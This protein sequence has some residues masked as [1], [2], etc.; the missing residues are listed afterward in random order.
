MESKGNFIDGSWLEVS[1]ADASGTIERENPS[2]IDEIVF[3]SNWSTAPVDLAVDAA[4]RALPAWDRLGFDGRLAIMQKFAGVLDANQE[5]LAARIAEEVG[6][7]LWEARGEARALAAKIKLM[8]T[9]GMRYTRTYS[10]DGVQGSTIHRPLG[11]LAV[12]GPFN[13]PMHLPNGHIVPGL[14]NGNT[15]VVKP[16]EMAGGCMQ[17]YFECAEEAGFPPGVL[18]LVQGPGPVGA[19]LST[20]EGVHGVLFTGSYETGLKIKQATLTQH[21]KLLALEMGGKNTSIVLEDANIEQTAHELIQAA[22]LT[23]GQRCTATSRVV[24]RREILDQL[25]ERV[26]DLARRITTGDAVSETA[27]MGPLIDA[28]AMEKFLAAQRDDEDG[29][30]ERILA[31]GEARPDLDGY[32]VSPAL[33]L[34]HEVDPLGSHQAGE[35]FGP[36]VVFYAADSDEEAAHIA[37]A[38]D[39]GL[40]MSV[41]SADR[42]RYED[43]VW[44]LE[45]GILNWN[46]STVGASSALPF[47]GVKRSGNHRPAA[48]W[49]GL[50]CTYPQAQLHLDPGFDHSATEQ[51]PLSLL[52]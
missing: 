35:I 27:F 29:S 9:E 33:W 24:A 50:Y 52:A 47:G 4:R 21:W 1:D 28:R 45:T 17:L 37:N 49:A 10:P 39:F 6:K 41:F 11:V 14:L 44:Q 13:F 23:C 5:R 15:I 18:N 8:S 42:A 32:F 40:A 46:R 51:L 31:G 22:F 19:A 12:L 20:H 2:R 48:A 43:L 30:L 16:S 3:R 34:A 36:D 7:P 26:T 25:I 38:T